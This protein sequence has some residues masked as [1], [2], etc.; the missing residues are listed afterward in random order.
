MRGVAYEYPASGTRFGA[1][2]V[3]EAA[4]SD[5]GRVI[6]CRCDCGTLAIVRLSTV[7]LGK[8]T[9]CES[10][11]DR[12]NPGRAPTHG[13]MLG[14]RPTPEY[15]T[16]KSMKERCSNRSHPSFANYGAKGIHVTAEWLGP[17]GFERFLAHIGR[18]PSLAH[19]IDRCDSRGNYEP[20]NVRWAT[21]EEQ[22]RNK[23]DTQLYRIGA[24]VMSRAEW[25]RAQGLRA[26][27][28]HARLRRG[29]PIA[30]ALGFEAY[31]IIERVTS[32]MENTG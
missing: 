13:A 5:G 4:P 1:W 11:R 15:Q 21:V 14:N 12:S 7:R 24:R 23:S 28:V 31:I 26:D 20:G 2:T 3:I 17:G 22:N 10:C 32:H 8:S 19:S 25:A 18:R 27:T 30:K 9:R 16:W 29:W 6:K